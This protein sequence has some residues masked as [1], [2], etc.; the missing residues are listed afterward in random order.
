MSREIKFRAWHKNANYMCQNARTNLLYKDYLEFMQYTGLKDKNGIEIYESD[1]IEEV[2]P[3][4][5]I[6]G[7]I[8]YNKD[9][10]EIEWISKNHFNNNILH[11]RT[12]SI[13]VVGNV[14][15]NAGLLE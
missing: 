12:D 3:E 10:F 15:Q 5:T 4:R 2:Y 1:I 11:V 9:S 8:I 13:Q 6:I 7:K 14:Y